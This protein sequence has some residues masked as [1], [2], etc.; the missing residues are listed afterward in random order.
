MS[1]DTTSTK[2]ESGFALTH[3]AVVMMT[4][5]IATILTY[6]VP[7]LH[8][9]RPWLP[10]DPVP[11]ARLFKSW[12][13][14]PAFAGAGGSYRPAA[15]QR[16]ELSETVGAVVASNVGEQMSTV[17]TEEGVAVRILPTEWEGIEVLIEDPTR[18]GMTPFYEALERT[19]KGEGGAVTRVAHYGDSSIATDLITYTL[20]RRLQLRFGDAGHGFVLMAKDYL[21]YRHRDVRFSSSDGWELR[22]VVRRQ[23]RDG[24][25]GYGGVVY[26]ARAG[27][28]SRFGT[29]A[30]GPVGRKVSRFDLYYQKRP[31]GGKLSLRVDKGERIVIDTSADEIRDAVH[32]VEVADGEHRLEVRYKGKGPSRAYGVVMERKGPGI[33]YDSLGLVGAR[34]NRLLNFD[35]AHIARQLA[36]RGVNLIVLGF[37]GNEAS[38]NKTE[39]AYYED[40]I[41]VL[42]HMRAGRD[43]VGCL[44]FSP[45]DQA[46]RKRGKI[47][48]LPSIPKIVAA[49]RQ[50]A[51]DAGCAFFNTWEAMGGENAMRRWYKARPRL[52]MGDFRHATPEGYEAIGNL[53]YKA[54][55]AGFADYLERRT[56]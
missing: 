2:Q 28:W 1:T 32:S 7:P 6:I 20:R 9:F 15:T 55:I 34:A 52:A 24:H 4:I 14:I 41:K 47:Q 54:L 56:P 37:G 16:G 21:P 42:E 3:L 49:Q 5:T 26:T 50:A 18:R 35:G 8:Q 38:D 11:V 33:V 27:A 45:L 22:E 40:Y 51:F 39:E 43:D 53:F 29:D 12:G 19:A 46:Q 30:R 36:R 23:S 25:Y 10:G 17:P 48:T 13:E 31:R 44:A